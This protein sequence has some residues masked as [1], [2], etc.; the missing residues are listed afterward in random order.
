MSTVISR[1]SLYSCRLL[2]NYSTLPLTAS[3]SRVYILLHYELPF[4]DEKNGSV[5]HGT[6]T[7]SESQGHPH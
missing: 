7:T 4:P 6:H 2:L 1:P 5:S 3:F